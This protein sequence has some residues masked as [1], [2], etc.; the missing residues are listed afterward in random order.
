MSA[1][2]PVLDGSEQR[3]AL[4]RVDDIAQLIRGARHPESPS[5][6]TGS[7]GE[8]LFFAFFEA[9]RRV[10]WAGELAQTRLDDAL[11]HDGPDASRPGLFSGAAG[12]AYVAE[13]LADSPSDDLVRHVERAR[14][15]DG[16]ICDLVFGCAGMIVLSTATTSSAGHSLM[17]ACF[18]HLA[19]AP[20]FADWYLGDN[21]EI[22]VGTAHGLCGVMAA[23]SHALRRAWSPAV[24]ERVS[25]AADW[26]HAT[27][28]RR[29]ASR[30][31]PTLSWCYG[32]LGIAVASV[33]AAG[34]G[35][36]R[37]DALASASVAA[38]L[39]ADVPH[40]AV[41]GTS[42]CHG[43]AGVALLYHRLWH[44]RG[45]QRFRTAAAEW[46]RRTLSSDVLTEAHGS[47]GLLLGAPGIG[48]ALLAA[49]TEVEPT[50]DAMLLMS[51]V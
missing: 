1:W 11:R 14:F 48:L 47:A 13:M 2:R 10:G 8:A 31:A 39:D 12:I 7:A 17:A 5:V 33:A 22:D 16:V 24:A 23:A 36:G 50:W 41:R 26:V 3:A 21:D 15:A 42:L 46:Y 9:C 20:R 35:L 40:R 32:D 44:S 25:N 6:A 34:G 30:A 19:A 28:A 49:A 29:R 27:L 18:E 43:T 45:E 51:R 37:V 4:A 38:A